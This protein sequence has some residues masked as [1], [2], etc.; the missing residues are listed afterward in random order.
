VWTTD[1]FVGTWRDASRSRSAQNF[2][3]FIAKTGTDYDA[4]LF[5]REFIVHVPLMRMG[6]KL[7][8]RGPSRNTL[9]IVQRDAGRL[10][11]VGYGAPEEMVRTST[12]TNPIF[13]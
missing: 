6:H 11:V 9:T 4:T 8:S 12:A 3:M 5:A 1:P 13:E 10:W 2:T 7:A